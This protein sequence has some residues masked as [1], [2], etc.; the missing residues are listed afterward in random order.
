MCCHAQGVQR[1]V[2]SEALT[3]VPA[4]LP[5]CLPQVQR[6][7]ESKSLQPMVRLMHRETVF[8]EAK[9]PGMAGHFS[10]QIQEDVE[11]LLEYR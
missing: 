1:H 2:E 3:P 11:V 6:L 4:P 8:E 9:V 10:V 5:C 7:V